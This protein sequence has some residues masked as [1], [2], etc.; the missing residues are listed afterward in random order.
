[1]SH[2]H[3]RCQVCGAHAPVKKLWAA[4]MIGMIIVFQYSY[5]NGMICRRCID[6]ELM[7]RTLISLFLG[8]WGVI[9]FFLNWVVLAA[10][11]GAFI[12]SRGLPRGDEQPAIAHPA[13]PVLHSPVYPAM[14]PGPPRVRVR[15]TDG[16]F[17]EAIRLDQRGDQ[18]LLQFPDGSQAWGPSSEVIEG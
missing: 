18:S 5:V 8:W 1:M 14:T 15:L 11:I 6:K 7:Q 3:G 17:A 16:S 13:A 9:S 2:Q 12:V 10:N 4:Q